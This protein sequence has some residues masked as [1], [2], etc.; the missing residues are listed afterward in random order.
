MSMTTPLGRGL[1]W[2]RDLPDQRD[3]HLGME[4]AVKL[5]PVVDLRP[6]CPAVPDQGRLGS[7]V[8]NATQG[9]LSF[10]ENKEDAAFGPPASRL[11]IYWCCRVLEGTTASDAGAEIRDGVK[12]VVQKGFCPEPEWPYDIARFATQPPAQCFTDARKDRVTRYL[13]VSQSQAGLM[14]CLAAGWPVVF[15]FTVY[16]SFETDVVAQTG[17]VPMPAPGEQVLGGHAVLLVG[18]D[19]AAQRFLVRNSWGTNWG[20][21]GYFTMP[22]AYLLDPNLASDFWTLR[23]DTV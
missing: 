12:S 3:L 17:V 4:T 6:G 21:S 5:P 18:Y 19:L 9:A 8:A 14:G 1:G 20:M 7:C 22:F 13:R 2:R 23:A 10:M 15:G 16:E 11:F